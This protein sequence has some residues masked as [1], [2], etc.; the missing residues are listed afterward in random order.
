MRERAD[1]GTARQGA[2]PGEDRSPGPSVVLNPDHTPYHPKWYRER[3]PITWWTRNR[4]Y[5]LFIARELTSVL[6]LY[7]GI[8]LLVQIVALDRGPEAHAAFQE[9]LA[10][11]WVIG[12]HLLVLG[13]LLFHTITWL[14][15]APAAIVVRLG[16]HRASA[17][18]VR[19]AHYLGWL[20]ASALVVFVVLQ[21][22]GG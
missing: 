5:T 7:G 15:L 22:T 16:R 3:I 14:S 1:A 9:W 21:L 2:P 17:A 12:L 19:L 6:V 13:G 20:A 8:L 11:P 18:A 10:R 4:R